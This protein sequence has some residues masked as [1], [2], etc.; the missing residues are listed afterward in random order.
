MVSRHFKSSQTLNEK[1]LFILS[2]ESGVAVYSH[3]FIP[4]GMDPQLLSGFISAMTQFIGSFVGSEQTRWKTEYGD[5]TV[6]LIEGSHRYIGVFAI[7]KETNE[8]RSKL[9]RIVAE[10]EDS[11]GDVADESNIE[12]SKIDS[13][14][15]FV[16]RIIILERLSENSVLLKESDWAEVMN[17]VENSGSTYNLKN[18]LMKLE[19]NQTIHNVAKKQKMQIEAVLELASKALWNNAIRIIYVPSRLD[20]LSLSDGSLTT[21]LQKDNPMNISPQTMKIISTF[22]GRK[23]VTAHLAKY[24]KKDAIPIYLE[25]GALINSGY[26]LR[27][28]MDRRIILVNECVLSEILRL[29]RTILGIARMKEFLVTAVD[30]G[31]PHHP[32]LTRIIFSDDLAVHCEIN[33]S[34]STFDLNDLDDALTYL[35]TEVTELMAKKSDVDH[36]AS[37]AKIAKKGC[38]EL[39]GQFLFDSTI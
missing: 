17:P 9:R 22:D 21:L 1:V 7:S 26:V 11:F 31:I 12:K 2:R 14:D 6:L 28:S 5:D 10:F 15:Q 30:S 36:I 37:A 25:L 32:W 27:I 16:R 24:K 23:P 35:L 3:E 33:D 38:Y 29:G 39:W 13:F 19:N 8:F 4:G 34:M 20:I 18:F